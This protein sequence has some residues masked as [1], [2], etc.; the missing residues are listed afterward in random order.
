MSNL[1]EH[2]KKEFEILGWTEED[3][4]QQVVCNNILE[5][6]E[7]F[8]KQGHTGTTGPYVIAYF[9]RLAKYG[10]LAPLTGED[11]EWEDVSEFA[12]KEQYQN[13]RMSSIFKDETGTYWTD[14]KIFKDPDG[15]TFTNKDSRVF[16][17]FPWH[18]REPE[19]IDVD[20][21]GKPI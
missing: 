4:M 18:L 6:I 7:A 19:I 2:A 20:E 16:I 14:G 15:Y 8:S 21:E 11:S 9:E 1:V 5:L 13:N 3:K 12:G 17:S 10:I